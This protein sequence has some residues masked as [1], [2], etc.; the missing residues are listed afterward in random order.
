[1]RTR[2]A[3]TVAAGVASL[4][5]SQWQCADRIRQH[6]HERLAETLAFA[7][8]RVPYYRSLGVDA[9][10]CRASYRDAPAWFARFPVLTKHDLQAAGRSMLADGVDETHVF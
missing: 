2:D 4:Q 10:S 6:Q 8:E 9:N 3:L 5:R 1:M 7:L